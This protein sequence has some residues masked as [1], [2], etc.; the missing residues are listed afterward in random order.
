M[1]STDTS[2]ESTLSR[3]QIQAQI[4]ALKAQLPKGKAGRKPLISDERVIALHSQASSNLELGELLMSEP[5]HGTGEGKTGRQHWGSPEAAA[6]TVAVRVS[7]LRGKGLIT[8]RFPAGRRANPETAM[9]NAVDLVD[10][11]S[12][13]QKAEILARLTGK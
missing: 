5:L 3:E 2:T 4:D 9:R 8:K 10:T 12:D 1:S 13:E 6:A 11:L 7:K